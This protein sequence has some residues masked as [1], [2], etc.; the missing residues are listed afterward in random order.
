MP[1]GWSS[2]PKAPPAVMLLDL[3]MP[4]MDGFEV[5]RAV[6]QDAAW[7][8]IPVVIITS[9]DLSREELEW[10]RGH[11]MDVFQKGAYGRAELIAAV[12]T[13]VEAVRLSPSRPV[14][15]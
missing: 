12:R 6:R 5:L 13:M 4:E 3:I 10:L 7:R 2:L 8:D 9:K 15:A 11:A 14:P 1:R